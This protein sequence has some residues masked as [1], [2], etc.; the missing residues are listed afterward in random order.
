MT[1]N[2][3][4]EKQNNHSEEPIGKNEGIYRSLFVASR[5]AIMTLE[6][7]SWRFTS[8]NPA[9]IEMF[10][11]KDEREFLSYPP[12]QLSPEFQPD[13]QSSAKKAQE[14][15]NVAMQK[16]TNFFEWVH[17]KITG[18]LF[19][20]EVLLS[21]VT[22]N[23]KVFLHAVIRDITERK[24]AEKI[25]EDRLR[26]QASNTMFQQVIEAIPVRIFWKDNNLLYL[27]C[28]TLF[29]R[30]AGKKTPDE[31]IGKSDYEMGWK[32]EADMYRKDDQM[33]LLSKKPKI[34]YEE[35]QTTPQGGIIW[36]RTSK[37]PL[38]NQ[39]GKIIGVL[40]T[41]EDITEHKNMEEKIIDDKT[42]DEAILDSIGDA[43]IACDKN[44][45]IML[46]NNM[47]EKI[48]GYSSL[49]AIGKHYREILKF[50]KETDETISEDFIAEAIQQNKITKIENHTLLINRNDEKIPIMNSAAP[51]KNSAGDIIG[52]VVVFHDIT[53]ER[54]IDKAKTEFVLLASH[55]L[56]TPLSAINWNTEL[57][58]LHARTVFS[59]KQL[60]YVEEISRATKRMVDL[61]NSLLDVSRLD[62][63]TFV[64]QEKDVNIQEV[65]QTCLKEL[66]QEIEKKNIFIQERY[67]SD[68]LIAFVDQKILYI[69]FQNLLSNSVKYSFEEGNVILT[70]KKEKE[71]I[72]ISVADNGIGIPS[73]EKESIGTKLYRAKN[74]QRIDPNGT[75]LGLYTVK[76]V[77]R[78]IGGSLWFESQ[79]NKGSIF[80]VKLP[81]KDFKE[82]RH[83]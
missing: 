12:W 36:L 48:S 64:V 67:A 49:E 56:R 60:Q 53:R 61:V 33:V 5:D 7:P 44:G 34:N 25:N 81:Y 30:D 54:Q 78:Y 1:D 41:Y 72:L 79:E 13:G 23:E 73:N 18:E 70:V 57:L 22:Y 65:V 20:A 71:N 58:L 45:I 83:I 51:F 68:P 50:I 4:K 74:V 76:E 2:P 10:K 11:A 26:L 55:Q 19:S 17:K 28:N 6:P 75:G 47:A 8:G 69:I 43:V 14:M 31:L 66:K 16:G 29:A 38:L 9:T 59:E 32:H 40:G 21:K 39:E 27:G 82:G 63:G 77:L 37:T 46:F 52:C 3:K 35:P 15:I 62:L 80:Y 42:K 24:K